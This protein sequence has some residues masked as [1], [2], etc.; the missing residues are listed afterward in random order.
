MTNLLKIS[1]AASIGLHT[2]AYL[3]AEP[4]RTATTREIAGAL[5]VSSAHLSKVLQRL[6]KAGLVKSTR[7]PKGGSRLTDAGASATLLEVFEAIEGRL[8]PSECL[9]GRKACA[10][11]GCM[12]GD[13]LG[14]V[15]ALVMGR[16]SN[17]KVSDL[18]RELG[19]GEAR[20]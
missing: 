18:V 11:G 2:A 7:G 6:E 16:L 4:G 5:G 13:L 1:D 3:A 10:A 12:L 15:N 14:T 9:L 8:T 17:G 20:Q 19:I